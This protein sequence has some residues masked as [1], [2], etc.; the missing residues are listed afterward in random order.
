VAL[1]RV[2][3]IP[4]CADEAAQSPQSIVEW[5]R[6]GA[7]AGAA[8]KTIKLGGLAPVMRAAVVGDF[9]G[10]SL[11]LASKTGEL[12]IGAAALVHLGYALPNVD[13]GINITNQSLATDFVRRPIRQKDG[14]IECP[15]GPGLGIEVDEGVIAK[16][17]LS[18]FDR[19]GVK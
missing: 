18:G 8:L 17:R 2:S 6:A 15:A 3:P 16:C 5:H 12:S 1:S 13:W 4:L 7:I 10:L 11:N 19:K 9:L 14:G